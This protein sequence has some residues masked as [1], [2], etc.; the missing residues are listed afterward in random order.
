MLREMAKPLRH[1]P[2]LLD[3]VLAVLEPRAG[4][5]V[6]DCTLGLGG[7]ANELL[8]RVRPGGRVIAIDFDSANVERAKTNAAEG[9]S[10]HHANFAAI[11]KVL[12]GEGIERVD[13]ILADLGVASPQIDD[14]LR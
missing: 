9:M 10:V 5:I 4:E 7:H 1:V 6:V 11:D 2:V 12:V 8:R 13:A 3:E 14:P